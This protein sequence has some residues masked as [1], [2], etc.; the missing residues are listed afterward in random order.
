MNTSNPNWELF[1]KI[2]TQYSKLPESWKARKIK[3]WQPREAWGNMTTKS[4]LDGILEHKKDREKQEISKCE[5]WL[6][7]Q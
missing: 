3:L 1:Y 5:I 6:M 7:F 4:E 2:P